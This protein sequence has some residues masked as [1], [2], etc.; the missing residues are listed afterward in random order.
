MPRMSDLKDCGAI[1]QDADVILFLHRQAVA[2]PGADDEWLD[3]AKGHLAKH[4]G[5]RTGYIDLLYV[6]E[7]TRFGDWPPSRPL[8]SSRSQ[9]KAGGLR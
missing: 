2:N 5:G 8:P 4:R 1:E 3:Y 6:G 9:S 7:N